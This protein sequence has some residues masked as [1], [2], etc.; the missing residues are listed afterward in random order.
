VSSS[1]LAARIDELYRAPLDEFVSRRQ[2]LAKTLSGEEKKQVAGLQKPLTLPWLVN[3]TYWQARDVYDELLSTGEQLRAAQVG[4]LKGRATDISGASERHAEALTHAIAEA[5][6][7]AQNAGVAPQ[8]EGLRRM[9]EAVSIRESLPAPHGRFVK[10]LEPGGFEA[11]AGI[12]LA[13][14]ARPQDAESG[15]RERETTVAGTRGTEASPAEKRRSQQQERRREED[16]RRRERE[17]AEAQRRR[18]AAIQAA[19]RRAT[20]ALE[21]ERRAKAA[22]EEARRAVHDA[23]RA[24]ADLLAS[25]E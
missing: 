7:I 18:K 15:R 25:D 8:D 19:E 23:D 4:A 20:Q 24:L 2:A 12:A 17:R 16:E 3:Q 14:P 6:R 13:P 9:F 5:A 11:L 22:W 10:P 1:S 21:A